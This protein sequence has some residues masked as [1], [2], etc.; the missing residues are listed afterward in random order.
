MP[1]HLAQDAGGNDRGAGLSQAVMNMMPLPSKDK[2]K[3]VRAA[4]GNKKAP[5][6]RVSRC[7]KKEWVCGVSPS[8][9]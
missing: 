5:G 7:E 6:R 1:A 2:P 4:L 8:H 9:L 3:D